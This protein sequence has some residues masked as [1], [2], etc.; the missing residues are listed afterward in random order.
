M[1]FKDRLKLARKHAGLTQTGLA[2]LVGISQ[3]SISEIERGLTS[4]SGY[5]IKLALSC[6]VRA[7]W[8]AYGTGPMTSEELASEDRLEPVGT[9]YPILDWNLLPAIAGDERPWL[10]YEAIEGGPKPILPDE[11]LGWM[12]GE[13]AGR[14]GFWLRV[15][16]SSMIAPSSPS[17]APGSYILVSRDFEL[18]SGK[19]YVF[20]SGTGEPTFKQYVV[21]AGSEYLRPLNPSFKT[22]EIDSS[23]WEAVGRVVD[24]KT[25]DL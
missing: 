11:A 5:V 24:T 6:G 17:F 12:K 20:I 10:K 21:D 4:Q 25:T 8:L 19:F 15:D 13:S 18:I 23:G 16:G 22:I 3:A 2:E 9:G 7:N 14:Y 1:E